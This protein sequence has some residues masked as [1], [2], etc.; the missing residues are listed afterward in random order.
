MISQADRGCNARD[1]RIFDGRGFELCVHDNFGHAHFGA[2]SASLKTYCD[3]CGRR[4]MCVV[5]VTY[6][7]TVL[8]D[9]EEYHL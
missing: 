3:V 5:W 7:T 2:K 4:P 6:P 9:F 1:Q 8:C